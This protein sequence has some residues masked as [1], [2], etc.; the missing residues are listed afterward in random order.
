MAMVNLGQ[1]YVIEASGLRGPQFTPAHEY[2]YYLVVTASTTDFVNCYN[3]VTCWT[4]FPC[5]GGGAQRNGVYPWLHVG[6]LIGS[7]LS[8][9]MDW[10]LD[11]TTQA[12]QG[13]IGATTG[14]GVGR[15]VDPSNPTTATQTGLVYWTDP[16]VTARVVIKIYD[17]KRTPISL[18][19]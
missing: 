13:G 10:Q 16:D 14:V 11:T 19:V 15:Y 18:L 17:G 2:Y 9:W 4:A 3:G 7:N 12:C 5:G 1:R 6:E 8:A